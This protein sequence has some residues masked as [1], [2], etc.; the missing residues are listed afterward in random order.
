MCS[1]SNTSR[2]MKS[3]VPLMSTSRWFRSSSRSRISCKRRSTNSRCFHE[4]I[5]VSFFRFTRK[6]NPEFGCVRIWMRQNPCQFTHRVQTCHERLSAHLAPRMGSC[7]TR[8][9][10]GCANPSVLAMSKNASLRLAT[11][12]E[13]LNGQH[14]C[15]VKA[16][17]GSAFAFWR[18]PKC[19][20]YLSSSTN[21]AAVRQQL[22][23][24]ISGR[25]IQHGSSD[26]LVPC[27]AQPGGHSTEDFVDQLGR[28][29]CMTLLQLLEP[30][31]CG[32]EAQKM[33]RALWLGQLCPRSTLCRTRTL[34]RGRHTH[35]ACAES[36]LLFSR[37]LL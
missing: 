8:A 34:C 9:E 36:P 27:P 19:C 23:G 5:I 18:D 25:L 1:Q 37:L 13:G 16:W 21:S 24:C 32:S 4:G 29:S 26:R 2:L 28:G 14:Q 7:Q 3:F 6:R 20:L 35:R 10:A 33:Q 12:P 30:L 22:P 31:A 11:C 15:V 17:T